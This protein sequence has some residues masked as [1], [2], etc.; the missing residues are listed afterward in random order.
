VITMRGLEF[1]PVNGR[2]PCDFPSFERMPVRFEKRPGNL[3]Q[4]PRPT[5]RTAAALERMAA[6][7]LRDGQE[8]ALAAIMPAD[9]RSSDRRSTSDKTGQ[10]TRAAWRVRLV[11]RYGAM[12]H[13]CL[14]A[15]VTDWRAVIDLELA[16][17]APL[18]FSRDHLKPRSLGGNDTTRNQR[19]AH[20]L[21]NNRRGSRLM[22]PEGAKAWTWTTYRASAE[23]VPAV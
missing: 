22:T 21:C 11:K 8:A 10:A 4:A 7:I 20:R 13:I 15:G 1:L 16:H 17:P 23:T 6:E 5:P 14:A 12:C 9:T 19:P 3:N 18:S 2:P